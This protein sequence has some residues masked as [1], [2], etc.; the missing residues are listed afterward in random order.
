ME[1]GQ[2]RFLSLGPHAPLAY[3]RWMQ[4]EKEK[5]K[6]KDLNSPSRH[7]GLDPSRWDAFQKK[8]LDSRYPGHNLPFK[9]RV[10]FQ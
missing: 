6:E 10:G 9:E 7:A 4:S 5:E 8:Y 3:A 1:F 2:D